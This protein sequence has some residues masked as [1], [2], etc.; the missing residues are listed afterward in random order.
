M[1][2]IGY[3]NDSYPERRTI[4]NGNLHE[5]K[6]IKSL[7]LYY[8]GAA[9]KRLPYFGNKANT[10]FL[11]KILSPNSVDGFHFSNS[12]TDAK[13]P[14]IST[15]ET[16][17]PRT[18]NMAFLNESSSEKEKERDL[19][20]AEYYIRLIASDYCKKIISLSKS[21]L[22]MQ[23]Y[24][25]SFFPEYK[26]TIH[27]KMLHLAPPQKKICSKDKILNKKTNNVLKFLF[28]GKDF[29][30]KGGREI[31]DVFY[32]I[33]K[34]T[35]FEFELK[36]VSL[37]KTDNYAFGMWQ[38]SEEENKGMFDKIYQSEK[39]TLI[40]QVENP[41]LLQMMKETDVGLLPTWADTYG[42]SVLEFQ[43]SG[44]PV[45][46]TNIRALPEINNEELGWMINLETDHFKE[47]RIL[48]EEEK[49]KHRIELQRQLKFIVLEILKHPERVKEK[50][51]LS[52]DN[53]S[54]KNSVENYM[55]QLS[56][57]YE[58]NF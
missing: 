2:I 26:D 22:E 32:Q 19:K 47:I 5:L 23:T 13:V 41:I 58:E 31:V 29:V 18:T 52:Y 30:R 12:I 11:E 37:G 27:K 16:F 42:Y 55:L 36:L 9:L 17:I 57:I 39:I 4:I 48:N 33:E 34:E 54:S 45:I 8:I 15:F 1:K 38:D 43:A 51:V 28:V 49:N 6:K 53:V 21:N 14:W 35:D 3:T 24:F 10:V 46:T 44:C 50:A 7:N 40:K 25:L 20:K 56:K